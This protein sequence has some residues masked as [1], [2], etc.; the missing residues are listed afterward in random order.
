MLNNR[1][2]NRQ[3]LEIQHRLQVRFE[4]V[5]GDHKAKNRAKRQTKILLK[6]RPRYKARVETPVY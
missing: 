5:L 6:E 1:D 2:G 3:Y 4:T